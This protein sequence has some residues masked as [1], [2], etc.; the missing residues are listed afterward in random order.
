MNSYLRRALGEE[1]AHS[2]VPAIVRLLAEVAYERADLL[3]CGT[4]APAEAE[5]LARHAK[6]L[7]VTAR[8]M[9]AR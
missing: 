4:A 6:R 9:E 1:L 8:E 2:S 7:E 5:R 3:G